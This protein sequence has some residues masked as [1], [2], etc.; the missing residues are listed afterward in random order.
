MPRQN[1]G[2]IKKPG[3]ARLSSPHACLGALYWHSGDDR[4]FFTSLEPIAFE[5]HCSLERA[6]TLALL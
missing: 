3:E 2:A 6:V 1:E 4:S 5:Q